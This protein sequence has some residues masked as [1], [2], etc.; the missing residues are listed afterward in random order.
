[1]YK[2]FL[3]K[4]KY[5]VGL[6]CSKL[7]WVHY[8]AKKQLPPVDDQTQALFN[9]GHRVGELAK[10]LYPGGIDIEWDVGFSEVINCPWM[11]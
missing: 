5:L 3:S 10:E 2:P 8:N 7:L 4:S 9:Q 11:L 1:M 6:Q